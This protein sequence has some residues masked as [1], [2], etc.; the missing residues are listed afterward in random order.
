MRSLHGIMKSNRD[1]QVASLPRIWAES[2]AGSGITLSI[3]KMYISLICVVNQLYKKENEAIIGENLF[4][5][6]ENLRSFVWLIYLFIS[7]YIYICI[8][9][10][11]KLPYILLSLCLPFYIR[12]PKGSDCGIVNVNIPTSGAEIGGAFGM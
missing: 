5:S 12:R 11:F 3:L 8:Y 4:F 1:F 9:I 7:V 6:I 2:F 10:F